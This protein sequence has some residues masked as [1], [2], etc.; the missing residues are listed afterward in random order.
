MA[1]NESNIPVV[2][3]DDEPGILFLHELMVEESNLTNQ[4]STFSNPKEGLDF[5]VQLSNEN[6]PLLV[7][8]DINMPAYSGWELLDKLDELNISE[9]TQVVM[10]TSS[11]HKSDKEKSS[12]YGRVKMYFEKPIDVEDCKR[13][14]QELLP[15]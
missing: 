14:K 11:I 15:F 13:I 3:I 8:L 2:I 4:I 12:V 7:I 1:N 6:T 5:I 9:N 10:A